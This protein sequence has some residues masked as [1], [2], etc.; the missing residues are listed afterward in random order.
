MNTDQLIEALASD[1]APVSRHAVGRRLVAGI[2]LGAIGT[3]L[4]IGLWLGFNPQLDV[5]MRHYSFWVKWGYTL[6]LGICAVVAT[7]R[8]ARPD[9]GTLGWLWVMALPVALLTA[10]GIFEMSRVPSAQWLAMW[11]GETWS[12]C[13]S[14]VFMLSLPI[15]GGL[16]WSF[17]RLAPTRL[18]AAGA[19]AGLTAGA[20]AA[21]LYCLHCPEVSA[22]FVLTWY[23]LGISLATLAGAVLGPRLMRW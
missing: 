20:W 18:R 6:S 2:A 9:S 10:I 23:T 22:I 5:A 21:T 16:L 19:T 15:F 4:L 13:S 11:L 3:I 7:T 14:I 8:L 12:V 1:V 17:R